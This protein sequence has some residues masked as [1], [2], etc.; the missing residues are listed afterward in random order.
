MGCAQ[1]PEIV[2]QIRAAAGSNV[3]K[4]ARKHYTISSRKC[5]HDN[6]MLYEL[7]GV[8]RP[9]RSVNEIKEIAKTTGNIVLSAGGVVRFIQDGIA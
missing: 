7:I 3:S 5:F 2:P 6:S 4:S 8:V 9:G 1:N